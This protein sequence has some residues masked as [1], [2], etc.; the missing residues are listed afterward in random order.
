MASIGIMVASFRETVQVWLESQLR[1]D[2]Y[3]RP[4]GRSGP[5]QFPPLPD[6]VVETARATPGVEA[7]D[8]FHGMAFRFRGERATLGTTDPDVRRR[9]GWM[10]F[11]LPG[12]TPWGPGTPSTCRWAAAA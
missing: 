9:Y 8:V 6:G 11:R 1:A 5:G 10:R 4:A 2:L 3:L 7:V 12:S